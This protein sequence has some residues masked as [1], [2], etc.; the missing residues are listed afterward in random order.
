MYPH[1]LICTLHR[2]KHM[3]WAR[4]AKAAKSAVTTVGRAI[5]IDTDAVL[6]DATVVDGPV[7]WGSCTTAE[8][9]VTLTPSLA[10][11]SLIA[12]FS[13]A[14]SIDAAVK[15]VPLWVCG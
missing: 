13:F 10:A 8:A 14:T 2:P 6:S 5:A 11:S 12:V 9:T 4:T 7:T 15:V 1:M 3:Q